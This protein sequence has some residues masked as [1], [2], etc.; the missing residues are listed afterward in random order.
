MDARI[1]D[2]YTGELLE[3][4]QVQGQPPFDVGSII[5]VK[6]KPRTITSI[7]LPVKRIDDPHDFVFEIKVK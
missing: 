5:L 2:H 6:G 3:M 7:D 4:G 1:F